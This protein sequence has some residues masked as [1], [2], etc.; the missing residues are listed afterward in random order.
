M[1][2]VGYLKFEI[3]GLMCV[4]IIVGNCVVFLLGNK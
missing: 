4:E 1:W 2:L 3:M